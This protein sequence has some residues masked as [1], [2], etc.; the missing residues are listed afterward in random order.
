MIRWVI[1]YVLVALITLSATQAD[2]R[3]QIK[4]TDCATGYPIRGAAVRVVTS[5]LRV[6]K[7]IAYTGSN[8][9]A[10]IYPIRPG[11][12]AHRVEISAYGYNMDS[13]SQWM[14]A[15]T[16]I[17]LKICLQPLTTA[18][19]IPSTTATVTAK[20]TATQ[21]V[22]E[23]QPTGGQGGESTLIPPTLQGVED[24]PQGNS[25]T[26]TATIE[27]LLISTEEI[28]VSPMPTSGVESIPFQFPCCAS[29]G[30]IGAPLLISMKSYSN[31]NNKREKKG[32]AR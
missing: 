17:A 1:V 6:D 5:E 13:I 4:V 12:M 14:P 19:T 27:P 32:Y 29:L 31:R 7:Q 2:I 25:I 11:D 21:V 22:S 16:Y 28:S 24:H 15:D 9:I 8:G 26:E 23:Q 20:P 18:T 3:I 10:T 30:M